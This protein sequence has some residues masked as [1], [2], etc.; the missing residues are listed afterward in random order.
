VRAQYHCRF[1]GRVAALRAAL[2]RSPAPVLNGIEYLEVDPAQTRLYVHFVQDLALAPALPLASTNV[3]IRGGVRVRDPV[4]LAVAV[5]PEP[6]VLTVDVATPG[7]FSPYVLRLVASAASGTP[8]PGIDQALAEVEFRFKVD[9]PSDFDC[10]VATDCPVPVPPAPAIDYLARDWPSFRRLLLDRLSTLLPEWRERSP[11]DLLVTLVEAVAHR[12]DELS[13]YQD[14]VATEAYLGTA[15]QRV[16]VRRHARLLDY[17]LHDGCNARAWVAF[18]T[19]VDG[20]LLRGCDPVTGLGGTRLLTR[21]A[22]LPDGA[23]AAPDAER[24]LDAAAAECFELV[25]DLT[26]HRAHNRIAFYTFS[27]EECCLPRGAVRAFLADDPAS[28]LQLQPGDVLVLEEVADPTNGV[29]ADADRSHRHAVRL[30]RVAP[31]TDAITGAAFVEVEWGAPDALPFALRL[32]ARIGGSLRQDLAVA[33]GNVGLC[34]HGRTLPPADLPAVTDR[35]RYRP[36]LQQTA[37]APLTQRSRT[38]L[39][40]TGTGPAAAAALSASDPADAEPLIELVANG[41]RRAWRPRTDLL[42]SGRFAEEFVVETDD[43]GRAMLRFGDDVHGRRPPLAGFAARLRIGNGVQGNVGAEAIAH[44]VQAIP[45][46][47][48]VRNPVPASGGSA[49]HPAAQARL[50]APA[51]FR[52]QERAVT[53]D[54]HAAMAERHPEVQRAVATRRWTGSWHTMFLTIDRRGGLPVDAAFEEQ[55]VRFLQ[56]F[57]LAGH[58]LEIDA[59]RFVAL[60]LAFDVCT[61]K[62]YVAD[63]VEQRLL[64]AFGTGVAG[65]GEPGFFHADRFT[66]GTP[67][68]LSAV[69]ARGM[70]VPGV[71][72]LVPRRFQRLG[73][74]PAGEIDDGLIRIQRL[75]IARL[76]NDP[77]APE[78]GRIEFLVEVTS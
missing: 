58:D 23:V 13:Y 30:L 1:R 76:D 65:I 4:V 33:T 36:Q 20:V 35:G 25:H 68:Y 3:E 63:D 37:R 75:E 74:K 45:D 54:D 34:D 6:E 26:L 55:L 7:D 66:F 67:V 72:S 60:D 48:A 43:R 70:R 18:T 64:A 42:A 8:P 56:T 32:S 16:S 24:A 59:P 21:T 57:R 12:A 2:E 10:K 49:P 9:C 71:A 29:A 61:A 5:G 41:S 28:P 73:R 31:A 62:G 69:L 17:A 40:P 19:A 46:V 44:V 50:Y 39:R 52:R 51:A 15:R 22:G 14:A 47:V 78:H 11:A 38:G 53:A 77:N 27:D